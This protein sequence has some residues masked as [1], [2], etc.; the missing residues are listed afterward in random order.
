MISN[1]YPVNMEEAKIVVG[2]NKKLFIELMQIFINICDEHIDEIQNSI[3][4]MDCEKLESSSHSLKSALKSISAE[5]ACQLAFELEKQGKAREI[6]K[7]DIYLEDLKGE[8][9][10]IK[11]FFNTGEWEKQF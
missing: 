6:V 4:R 3:N 2:N 7:P 1:E 11:L 9:S 8:I 5:Q 10:R